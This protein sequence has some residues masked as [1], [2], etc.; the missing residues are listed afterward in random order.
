VGRNAAGFAAPGTEDSTQ[1]LIKALRKKDSLVAVDSAMDADVIVTVVTHDWRR[2]RSGS[3]ETTIYTDKKG[4]QHDRGGGEGHP[5]RAERGGDLRRALDL[6]LRRGGRDP[7]GWARQ[8]RPVLMGA[9]T[10]GRLSPGALLGVAILLSTA[11]CEKGVD[12][13]G[14]VRVPSEVQELVSASAPGDVFVQMTHGNTILDRERVAYLCGGGPLDV[15]VKLFSFGCAVDSPAKVTAWVAPHD[16]DIGNS[17]PSFECDQPTPGG[18][19]FVFTAQ[20]IGFQAIAVATQLVPVEPS[21]LLGCKN[22][23]LRFDL[24]LRPLAGGATAD[25]P[26]R[27]D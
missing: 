19:R 7:G 17:P 26:R 3:Y 5:G 4:R 6:V 20:P 23:S 9:A 24:T 8:R 21:G 1:D 2:V 11:G 13:K 25:I 15:D 22:G 27:S 16:P 12:G 10:A 18:D 14:T